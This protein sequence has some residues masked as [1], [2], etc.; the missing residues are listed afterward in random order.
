MTAV[1]SQRQYEWDSRKTGTIVYWIGAAVLA[2]LLHFIAIWAIVHWMK[3]V[4]LPE[5][6][7][8]ASEPMQVPMA[9]EL[10][11]DA[12]AAAA[13]P[14]PPPQEI[15]EEKAETPPP[16]TSEMKADDKLEPVEKSEPVETAAEEARPVEPQPAE[17]EEPPKAETPQEVKQTELPRSN[18]AAE[19][20]AS[21]KP[22]KVLTPQ[23][24]TP[25]HVVPKRPVPPRVEPTPVVRRKPIVEPRPVRVATPVVDRRAERAAAAAAE[26]ASAAA[27]AR[28][29]AAANARASAAAAARA[30]AATARASAAAAAGA[31]AAAAASASAASSAS[32]R[33]SLMAHLN[34][35]KRFP[36]GASPGSVSVAF[37]IDRSGGVRSASLARSSGNSI[38]DAEA[39]AMVRRAS[40]VPAPPAG[41]GGGSMAISVPIRYSR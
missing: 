30:S 3:P 26:R 19:L 15:P 33:A 27:A 29:S 9:L 21:A 4:E 5:A 20:A 16:P 2:G 34:R 22:Q 31:R 8:A 25:A 6:P 14:Q 18:N 38:L 40:P 24:P 37:T 28:A 1:V 17:P 32:W 41:V 13:P 7:S 35:F 12:P 10:V 23:L 39:V 11:Q 36:V